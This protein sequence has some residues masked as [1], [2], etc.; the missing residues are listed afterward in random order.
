MPCR[1][2]IYGNKRDKDI[3]Q[4][5]TLKADYKKNWKVISKKYR[6][7]GKDLLRQTLSDNFED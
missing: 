7:D 2:N 4:R 1:C 5:K 3:P 6:L